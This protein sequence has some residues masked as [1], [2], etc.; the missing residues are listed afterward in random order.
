MTTSIIS[1]IIRKVEYTWFVL[2]SRRLTQYTGE[3]RKEI[4]AQKITAKSKLEMQWKRVISYF[5]QVHYHDQATVVN[6]D[7]YSSESK[8]NKRLMLRVQF[9]S[10][11]QQWLYIVAHNASFCINYMFTLDTCN[12][13][14]TSSCTILSG[15]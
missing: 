1:I 8:H 10:S 15:A 13:S 5:G 12:R 2:F 9:A 6:K 7:D 11:R 4:K 3:D 14:C